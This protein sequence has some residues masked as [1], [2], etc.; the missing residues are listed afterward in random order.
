MTNQF[1]LIQQYLPEVI[2]D[3][4]LSTK[5]VLLTNACRFNSHVI[6]APLSPTTNKS[7]ELSVF[8][9]V[10]PN[11]NGVWIL[12]IAV[13]LPELLPT[14]GKLSESAISIRDTENKIHELLLSNR[15]SRFHYRVEDKAYH[16][17]SPRKKPW[18]G[19]ARIEHVQG[20]HVDASEEMLRT[21][22]SMQFDV[23][24]S[25]AESAF[26]GNII[27]CRKVLYYCINKLLHGLRA[28]RADAALSI[29]KLHENNVSYVYVLMIGSNKSDGYLLSQKDSL[30]PFNSGSLKEQEVDVVKR[31]ANG[32][33][34]QSD[35][36][37][38]LG[39]ARSSFY[40]GDYEFAFLQ[41]VI[42]AEIATARI[43]HKICQK[44]GVSHKRIKNAKKI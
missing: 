32:T 23:S 26:E 3:T 5:S 18:H 40:N 41:S 14:I 29:R 2:E 15:M 20:K 1:C 43:V 37:L 36:D 19:S 8:Q 4:T 21:V 25:D 34:M 12:E 13:E 28:S 10:K 35:I 24:G 11:K 6:L 22:A 42:A 27:S 16:V 30:V 7:P 9:S 31:I 17:L 33:L 38:L 44:R 39:E